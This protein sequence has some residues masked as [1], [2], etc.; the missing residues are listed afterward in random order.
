M[1]DDQTA[2]KQT[3]YN[4]TLLSLQKLQQ[5]NCNSIEETYFAAGYLC[6][7][8]KSILEMSFVL[9]VYHGQKSVT[10]SGLTRGFIKL[11]GFACWLENVQNVMPFCLIIVK[12][13]SWFAQTMQ[14]TEN[15][16]YKCTIFSQDFL[17]RDLRSL[18]SR[19][20]STRFIRTCQYLQI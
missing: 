12:M 3:H 7:E 8:M 10:V 11:S 14:I 17:W 20:P 18:K 13:A 15:F 2:E 4:I 9:S 19:K 5:S 6:E 1:I 16:M